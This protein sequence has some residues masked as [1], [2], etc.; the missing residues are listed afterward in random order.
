[1]QLRNQISPCSWDRRSGILSRQKTHSK[2]PTWIQGGFSS[3]HLAQESR[4]PKTTN[5]AASISRS[6]LQIL[7][8]SEAWMTIH[9]GKRSNFKILKLSPLKFKPRNRVPRLFWMAPFL[10][11][12]SQD[13]SHSQMPIFQRKISQK[14]KKPSKEASN[15][16][17]NEINPKATANQTPHS[18]NQPN[19]RSI[20]NFQ[21][22]HKIQQ[23]FARSSQLSIFSCRSILPRHPARRLKSK[24]DCLKNS[25][26]QPE[27][28]K[29]LLKAKGIVPPMRTASPLW[30]RPKS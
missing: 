16:K 30:Q 1:M 22:L 20:S 13:R 3:N 7:L 27:L 17:G 8:P 24:L 6:K 14:W 21:T 23:V 12:N 2:P 26:K 10:S 15:T 4:L 25:Q 19:F 5:N 11:T 29:N 9:L 18:P 28:T